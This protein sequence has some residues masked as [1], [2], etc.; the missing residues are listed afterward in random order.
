MTGVEDIGEGIPQFLL[1]YNNLFGKT[2][3]QMTVI[4]ALQCK[5]AKGLNHVDIAWKPMSYIFEIAH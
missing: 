3:G 1:H 2:F 4:K 5:G